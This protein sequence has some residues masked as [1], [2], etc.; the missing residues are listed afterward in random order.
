MTTTGITGHYRVDPALR[1][2]RTRF[3]IDGPQGSKRLASALATMETCEEAILKA[4]DHAGASRET[5]PVMKT[6]LSILVNG[7]GGEF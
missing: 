6:A 4:L 7:P 5:L 3:R 2:H 1:N